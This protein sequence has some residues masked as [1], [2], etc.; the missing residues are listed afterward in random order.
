MLQEL[1]VDLGRYVTIARGE[2]IPKQAQPRTYVL[3]GSSRGGTSALAYIFLRKGVDLGAGNKV[4]HEDR[5]MAAAITRNEIDVPAVRRYIEQRNTEKDV[6]GFKL[7]RAAMHLSAIEAELRNP[8]FVYIY[9]NPVSIARSILQREKNYEKGIGGFAKA[10]NH[11]SSFY[12]KMSA[13]IAEMGSP[14]ILVEYEKLY[15]EPCNALAAMFD[16]L[17]W[18]SCGVD[19]IASEIKKPGYKA[20]PEL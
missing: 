11:A 4:N 13:A 19:D 18:S 16:A 1:A 17:H 10:L 6:W 14:V 5:N 15:Y 2:A 8:I 20:L 3:A 7:P 9:R 12:E